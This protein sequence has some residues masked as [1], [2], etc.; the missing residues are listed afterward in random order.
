MRR[1][2]RLV[3]IGFLGASLS[4]Q[5][6]QPATQPCDKPEQQQFDFWLGNWDL[7]SPSIKAY[8][9]VHHSN[10]IK[11]ILGGCI[12]EENFVGSN[13]QPP[14]LLGMSVSVFDT[15][16]NQWKQTWVDN[17]GS[18]LDFAGEFKDN[19]MALWREATSPDGTKIQQRMVWKNITANEFDWSWERSKD[20]GKTWEILWPIHYKRKL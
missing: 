6:S 3:L 8:E 16:A 4:A 1:L 10:T 15:S 17:Q 14:Q 5:T 12:V 18:Y 11:R 7:T 20:N 13:T 9:T 19:Q 2:H